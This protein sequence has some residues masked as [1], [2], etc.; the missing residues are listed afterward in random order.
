[1]DDGVRHRGGFSVIGAIAWLG[2]DAESD[3]SRR[4]QSRL[5]AGNGAVIQ[6]F[7]NLYDRSN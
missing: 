7:N 2:I 6:P 5:D 1:M 4:L 3:L